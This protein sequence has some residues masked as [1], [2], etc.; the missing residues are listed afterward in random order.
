MVRAIW[1]GKVIAE[2]EKTVLVE[3]NHYFPKETVV[4]EY[5]EDSSHHTQCLWKG[6]A[7]YYHLNVDGETNLNAAW[8]YPHPSD[9]ARHIQDHI[10]FWKGVDVKIVNF[11]ERNWLI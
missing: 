8:H 7:S 9:A 4:W 3:G 10:A 2:S 11:G 1:N 6:Q 5:F